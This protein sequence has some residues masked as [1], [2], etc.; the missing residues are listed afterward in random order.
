MICSTSRH[1]T[2]SA[3]HAEAGVGDPKSPAESEA[4]SSGGQ[5]TDNDGDDCDED[6]SGVE[7]RPF[8]FG[9]EIKDRET[10]R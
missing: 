10:E 3:L 7:D 6:I 5:P 2:V 1:A 8:E 4:T 9:M